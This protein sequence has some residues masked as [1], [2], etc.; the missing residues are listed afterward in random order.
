MSMLYER[1]VVI[2]SRLAHSLTTNGLENP[3]EQLPA[4]A[5]VTHVEREEE[6]TLP[7]LKK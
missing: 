3:A 7:T 5:A 2:A 4:A 1:I 6:A